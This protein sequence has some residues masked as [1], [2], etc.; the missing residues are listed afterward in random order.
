MK[1]P[2]SREA[3]LK[4]LERRLG[5]C[6]K[7]RQ[8]HNF[9]CPF[10]DDM[11]Y[12]FGVNLDTGQCYCFKCEVKGPI[13]KV[14]GVNFRVKKGLPPKKLRVNLAPPAPSV[15]RPWKELPDVTRPNC[16]V[17]TLAKDVFKYL[18]GRG[19]DPVTAHMM[20][21]GYGT[22]GKWL[23]RVIHPYYHANGVLAG[24][25]GRAIHEGGAKTLTTTQDDFPNALGAS[26]GAVVG[27]EMIRRGDEV[28]VCEGPYDALSVARVMP[29]VAILGSKLHPAQ[30]RRMRG[31]G[32]SRLIMAFD[33]DK[34][35]AAYKGAAVAYR[36]GLP[37]VSVV[38]WDPELGTEIDF[39]D[40]TA[41]AV[42]EVLS[43]M[44]RR[45]RPGLLPLSR[46][47]RR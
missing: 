13:R 27:L 41:E 29:A 36:A 16:K 30:V 26:T 18:E 25:Q 5:P 19:I 45:W 43:T 4:E 38:D 17:S 32:A 3:A 20:G 40:L 33:P 31:A 11:K 1:Q 12:R 10:C 21:L 15:G 8:F 39:G 7:A 47:S 46:T 37:D 28:A 9:C 24:W 44:S 14:L 22:S 23:H 42:S 34:P 2:I 35:K 6:R